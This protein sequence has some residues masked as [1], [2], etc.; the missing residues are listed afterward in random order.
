MEE[1]DIVEE[2]GAFPS[3]PRVKREEA[4]GHPSWYSPLRVLA[5]FSCSIF[6]TYVDRGVIASNGVQGDEQRGI[7]V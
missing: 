2:D 7:Q 6:F 5:L 3:L 4:S 1:G